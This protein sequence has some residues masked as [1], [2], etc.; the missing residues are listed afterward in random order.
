MTTNNNWFAYVAGRSGGHLIPALTLAQHA[1]QQ[2][3]SILMFSTATELDKD[4]LQQYR[5]IN[6]SIV[7]ALGNVPLKKPWRLP[8][9]CWQFLRTII[10]S[11]RV[12]KQYKP[13][14]MVSTGGYIALPVC[15]AAK[16]LAIPIELHELNAIPGKATRM[17]ARIADKINICF[18][19]TAQFFPSHKTVSAAYPL[20]YT[21]ADINQP[22]I[23]AIKETLQITDGTK[24]LF[25]LGG[26][27]GSQFINKTI[28]DWCKHDKES[29]KQLFIIHQTGKS[30]FVWVQQR[31][32]ELTIAAHV[33]A[34]EQHLLPYYLIADL[35]IARAGAG[36]LF[37]LAFFKKR[38]IIIPLETNSTDHQLHNAYAIQKQYPE[39][40]SVVRQN[41]LSHAGQL[42]GLAPSANV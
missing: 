6:K 2:E 15:V 31:Y 27:Q 30:D 41:D 1:K 24:V 34:Y 35:V 16:L 28:I 20:Q 29:A 8:L 23:A 13:K 17:L 40:F 14:K 37:E 10:H 42:S 38:S 3:C 12:L 32:A 7:L 18:E 25:V 4:I 11:F 21:Q 22:D 19:Q 39:L 5:C 9:F 33:F 36:T 26:S